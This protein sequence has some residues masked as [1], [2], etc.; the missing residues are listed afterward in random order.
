[1]DERR[2]KGLMGLC[3]RAG[4]AVFGEEGC[5]KEIT[6]GRSGAVLLDGGAS[7]GTRKRYTDW[8]ATAEVP[9]ILLP[10]GLLE[11]ATGKPGRA[12]AVLKGSFADRMIRECETENGGKA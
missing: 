2:M 10:E 9:L 12:M 4:Q 3:V 6:G 1:M 7:D 5:R 8:C 11:E